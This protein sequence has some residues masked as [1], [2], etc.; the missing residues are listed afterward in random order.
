MDDD[1]V[2]IFTAEIVNVTA[3][4]FGFFAN[5]QDVFGVG[6]KREKD[7]MLN[8]RRNESSWT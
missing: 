4:Q 3:E 8:L 2:P 7:N 6:S 5:N 1:G